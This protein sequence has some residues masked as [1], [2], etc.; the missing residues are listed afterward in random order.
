MILTE[1]LA[2][3]LG[4]GAGDT[5]TLNDPDGRP[6]E[7]TVTGVTENYAMHFIYMTPALYEK[8]FG[9]EPGY[10]TVLLNLKDGSDQS[11]LS[12]RLLKDGTIL[13]VSYSDEGM[14]RFV[15]T[16]GS[17]NSIVWVLIVSAGALAFIVMYNLVNINVNER[18]RELATI[19]VLGFY[20]KEVAAYIYRENNI[21][22]G[23]GLLVG[24]VLGIFLERF[25]IG[26]RRG[27]RG[28][29][30]AGDQLPLLPLFCPADDPVYPDCNGNAVF[31][32]QEDRHGGIPQIRRIDKALLSAGKE[33]LKMTKSDIT[34][35]RGTK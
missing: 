29:V 11:T 9:E 17:L 18:V 14:Q 24:L 22:A 28:H 19:K 20:D 3:M 8:S 4:V 10:N 26:D 15:D 25:V 30:L 12:E 34:K 32:A 6:I 5:V 7:V 33:N 27:G 35:A 1:K 16:M 2:K 31:P 23:L 13:G 21:A